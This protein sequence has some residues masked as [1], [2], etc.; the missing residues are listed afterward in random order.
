[1]RLLVGGALVAVVSALSACGGS[2]GEVGAEAGA[3]PSF[4]GSF[5]A[6]S[7]DSAWPIGSNDAGSDAPLEP[8]ADAE[9]DALP[10]PFD[11]GPTASNIKHVVLIVQENHTF[12]T[13]FGRYCTA[14]A[15]SNP[16]CTTGP[17]CCEAA[18]DKEPSGASPQVLD[19]ALNN[20]HDPTHSQQCEQTEMNLGK[21]DRYVT[22][23]SCSDARNFAI[24]PA[25]V[26][27]TYHGWAGT[28]A[29][30]DRYF[31]PIVG[32][33]SSNDMY[34]AE[35]RHVFT[36]NTYEPLA[37]GH[38]CSYNLNTILYQSK[39]TIADLL[40]AAGHTF[41]VYAQGYDKM[42][43]ALFCPAVPSDCTFG[44]P[45]SPCVFDP[46]DIPFEYYSQ[47]TDKPAFMRDYDHLAD[48]VKHGVLPTFSFV[49]ALQYHDE[50]PGY[51]TS[52]TPG[53]D[54]VKQTVD[55]ILGSS[56]ASDTLILL[57]W[58]E[59]GGFY[60]H[61]SPPP[62]STV[63]NEG[64]GTRVPLL[65]IGPFARSNTVSHVTM[66]H[67]SVVKFLEYN[68][69]GRVTGQLGARDAVVNN[70]GSLLDPAKT[71]TVIPAN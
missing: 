68:F 22:G 34:F 46:S 49:K 28:Y 67:S 32:A 20:S 15:G 45:T 70:L 61:V 29:L 38:G 71:G 25:S 54:F 17:S 64:Y 65:A 4:D 2:D 10:P 53:V 60:D 14:P 40:L 11:A 59:G 47:L 24:A 18:P 58:D 5:D 12:D 55:A 6:S 50:H 57:T 26:M 13:Y 31:Q 21:M 19:D 48:D 7:P 56:F 37:Q 42:K 62:T 41:S 1:M 66:E 43:A 16:T 39:T 23:T 36:D 69:L 52:I 51:G 63:D 33:S 27:T 9:S 35:A 3:A 8:A 44:L 30:A